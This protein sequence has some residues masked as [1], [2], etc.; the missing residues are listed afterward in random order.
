MLCITSQTPSVLYVVVALPMALHILSDKQGSRPGQTRHTLGHAL[1]RAHRNPEAPDW[2]GDMNPFW[3]TLDQIFG[4]H[5]NA[6]TKES[7]S[8]YTEFWHPVR[9]LVLPSPDM[10]CNVLSQPSS[11][12][13]GL[14]TCASRYSWASCARHVGAVPDACSFPKH[15]VHL[16]LGF[17]TY[18][19]C[20]L[21][22]GTPATVVVAYAQLRLHH[23]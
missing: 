19:A 8:H 10:P 18:S 23:V 1:A 4:A 22:N 2:V 14:L 6:T 11:R 17:R 16:C 7:K 13:T 12:R 9:S 15:A 20:V 3:Q 5:F 21:R